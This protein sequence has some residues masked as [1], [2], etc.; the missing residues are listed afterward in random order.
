MAP[1]PGAICLY[2]VDIINYKAVEDLPL[3]SLGRSERLKS[4]KILEQLFRRGKL[5][6][7]GPFRIL[8]LEQGPLK[9]S[10]TAI[11]PL[12]AGF[13]T[14]TKQFRRAVDRNRIKRM[15]RETYRLQKNEIL[16]LLLKKE[17]S[18][19]LF[20]LFTGKQIPEYS[21]VYEQMK[22]I[23]SLLISKIA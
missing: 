10:K 14:G 5:V 8:Y 13:G 12:Q 4:R 20:M 22:V 2:Q 9:D 19:S 16:Q 23:L 15:M 7:H 3:Y 6:V 17:H 11:Q 21:V 1:T 18:L